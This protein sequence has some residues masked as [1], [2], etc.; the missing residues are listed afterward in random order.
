HYIKDQ[1]Q[2]LRAG[3][4][5]AGKDYGPRLV[6]KSGNG[7]LEM[8]NRQL[9]IAVPG[10]FTSAFLVLQKYLEL[11]Q[12]KL[13][14]QYQFCSYN[15]VFDLLESNQVDASLLI[16]ESQLKYQEHD[17]KLIIDLGKWWFEKYQL[18]MPLGCNVINRDLGE[19]TIQAIDSIL[20]E[21]IQWGLDN[22]EEVLEYS[23]NFANN[24]LDDNAA[25]KY[26]NMYVNQSTV[27][28]TE[29]DLKSIDILLSYKS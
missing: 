18:Q 8:G 7:D 29:D 9:T 23:R 14:P 3:A 4:S 25:A 17:C 6:T 28:L 24:N 10:K 16:H 11:N 21:S 19:E 12:P 5:M 22:F 26:I 1:F 27:A 13:K 2:I 20:Q 15:E